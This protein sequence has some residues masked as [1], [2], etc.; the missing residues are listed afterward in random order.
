M[1]IQYQSFLYYENSLLKMYD[2]FLVFCR[3]DKAKIDLFST[4]IIYIE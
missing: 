3:K 1:G 2:L 4:M